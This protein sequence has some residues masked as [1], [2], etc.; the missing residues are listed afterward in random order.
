MV[1]IELAKQAIKNAGFRSLA[2]IDTVND[3]AYWA[4]H[5]LNPK[6]NFSFCDEVTG[7]NVTE[8]FKNS[9]DATFENNLNTLVKQNTN[10]LSLSAKLYGSYTITI[11]E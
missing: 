6:T 2:I 3:I 11:Y 7:F 9:S 1:K 10:G 5:Y 4:I 8:V